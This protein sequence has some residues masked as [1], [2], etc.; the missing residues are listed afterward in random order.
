MT[1]K[2]KARGQF[3]P[4]ASSH[5]EK[6][7]QKQAHPIHYLEVIWLHVAVSTNYQTFIREVIKNET[8]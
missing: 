4:L 7:R 1:G 6:G 8:D 5:G 2:E 3:Y